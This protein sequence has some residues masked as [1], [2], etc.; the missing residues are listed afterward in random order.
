VQEIA[1]EILNE[2]SAAF[3]NLAC[4]V[5]ALPGVAEEIFNTLLQTF[6]CLYKTIEAYF[7]RLNDVT[8]VQDRLFKTAMDKIMHKIQSLVSPWRE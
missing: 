6:P 5:A 4:S 8:V 2:N 1:S 7:R 3:G